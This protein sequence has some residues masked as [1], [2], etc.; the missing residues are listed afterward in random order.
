MFYTVKD[1]AEKTGLTPYTI[2]F[3]LKEGLLP[4]V[5]RSASG[6][7]LFKESDFEQIYMIECLKNCGMTI[8]EIAQYFQW[9]QEGDQNIDKCLA[10]F[11][12]K[13]AEIDRMIDLLKECK[14]A[15]R[16]KIWYYQTAKE[17]GTLSVHDCKGD[18][19]APEE[20][21]EIRS[22]MKNVRRL[23]DKQEN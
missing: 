16:Y 4:G 5:E 17:A 13:E 23:I 21:K 10:L 14:D 11:Q 2:R 19:I 22:R 7:R 20:M 6:T 1:V 12:Q 3:Y 8:A 18:L 9:Y 15:A